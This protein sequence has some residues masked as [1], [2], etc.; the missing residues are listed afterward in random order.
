MTT[1][2]ELER[3]LA[4]G[5]ISRREFLARTSALGAVSAIS[6]VLFSGT[7]VAAT[8]KKGG[9]LRVGMPISAVT[10]QPGVLC[11]QR[12]MPISAVTR[13]LG[14]LCCQRGMPISAW[15]G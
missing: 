5:K 1:L 7:A 6:P 11:C 15:T 8:P 12:G 14:V 3:L 4:R 13:Q 2:Q 10:S 9:T